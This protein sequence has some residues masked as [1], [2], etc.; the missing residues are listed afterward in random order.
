MPQAQ[1]CFC[2]AGHVVHALRLSG[3]QTSS[4]TRI[5]RGVKRIDLF[6]LPLHS[7]H[8]DLRTRCRKRQCSSTA[9][10][11]T[12]CGID[13]TGNWCSSFVNYGGI[14][15]FCGDANSPRQVQRHLKSPKHPCG[16]NFH[17]KYIYF[18]R[19]SHRKIVCSLL[20]NRTHSHSQ[21]PHPVRCFAV[22]QMTRKS[23]FRPVIPWS[24]HA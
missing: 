11:R 15:S 14:V 5:T 10:R 4:I 21:T 16:N 2:A 13:P 20:L 24:S 22:P 3:Q 17:P 8:E 1:S 23:L 12:E 18:G 9:A 19:R 6:A 7:R